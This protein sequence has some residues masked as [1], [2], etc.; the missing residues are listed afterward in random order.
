MDR[1]DDG[2]IPENILREKYGFDEHEIEEYQ[3]VM[4]SVKNYER[5]GRSKSTEELMRKYNIIENDYCNN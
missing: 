1:D 5:T 3:H 2:L 4:R